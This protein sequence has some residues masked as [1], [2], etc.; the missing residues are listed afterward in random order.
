VSDAI[1]VMVSAIH[2]FLPRHNSQSH[3]LHGI[4]AAKEFGYVSSQR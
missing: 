3:H 1:A 2:I 4:I